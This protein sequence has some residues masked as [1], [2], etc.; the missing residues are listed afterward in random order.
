MIA[1]VRTA[2]ACAAVVLGMVLAGPAAAATCPVA[3][4]PSAFPN[5]ADLQQSEAFLAKLGAR[6][7][8]S[9][10]QAEYI[11]WIR[12]QLAGVQGI[13]YSTLKYRI[14]RWSPGKA[15][16][17]LRINGHRARLP[18]ADAIPYS[19]PTGRKGV[20][21]PAVYV[22]AD[23]QITAAN[24]AGRIVIR[25][26]PAG[27]VPYYDLFLPVVSWETY[28]PHN[29]ID[30][31][32][33]LFGDFINYLPR[34]ADL[35][36]AATAGA[37][38]IVFV[39]DRPRRQLIGHYEPYEGEAWK[40][41]GVFLG[42]D[43]GKRIED[44]IAAG[45]HPSVRIVNRASFKD[46]TTPSLE[47]TLPGQSAQRIVI[48]SHTDGTNAVEDNGPIAMVAMV[49]Y[50]ASL[51]IECRPRTIQFAFSTAHFYQRVK[52]P[53]VR[54]GG[55]EQLAEQLDRDYD[56]GTV[57]AVVVLE[58]LGARDFEPVARTDGGPGTELKDTG[59]RAIQFIGVTP[60]PSLVSTVDTVV[61]G[62]DMQRTIL[63][64]GSDAPG[65]SVPSHCSFGGEGTPYERHLLP[66]IGVIAAPQFLYDPAVE[67]AGIDIN[68]MHSEMLGFTEL[69]NRM[70]PMSQSDIAG[71]VDVERQERANGAPAC[72]PDG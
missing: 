62:Y 8:G 7:T 2:V 14:H 6:P 50:F 34:V 71:E 13:N 53:A 66:T 65:N 43:E 51:P 32:G 41:P 70:Q 24:S 69:I 30:P 4:D 48:D 12:T 31:T 64:Q 57:S 63:L 58:H 23:Q 45:Q 11:D 37:K 16:L 46:V 26:A 22:P 9:R 59:L 10:T 52:D 60:S 19:R 15:S 35:R 29:T 28:D 36:A 27:S 20:A 42:S 3:P 17:A 67:L 44:A 5:V 18:I 56:K 72:P 33:N 47:V 25:D 1:P 68:V 54:D 49:H 38:G 21:G 39:K 55:A 40:V 61:R